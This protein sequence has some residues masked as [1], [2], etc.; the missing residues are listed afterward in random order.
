VPE[1]AP[2]T[3]IDGRYRVLDRLGS[4][5]MADVFCAEDTQLGRRVAL[6]LLH[7]RFAAD[8]EFVERFRREAQSAAGLQHPNI[9]GIYDRGQW[10][11]TSYIA[12]EYLP[13]RTLKELIVAEAPLAPQRAIE[14]TTQI[15]KGARFA[16]KRGVIHRDLKPHN[17]MVDDEDRVKVTDFGIARAG[18]SDM[19]ETGSILGT[20]QYLSPEQA[21]GHAVSEQSD[22]Y[23][24][25]VILYELLTGRLPFEAD[26][27]VAIAV[28]HVSETPPPP[29]ALNAAIPPELDRVVLWALEKDP[30]RRPPDADALLAAL[31][32]VRAGLGAG[33]THTTAFVP[34][35]PPPVA[36]PADE[37]PPDEVVVEEEPSRRR[38][39]LLL[40]LLL[41]LLAGGGL[42]AYLLTRPEKV[43]VLTV[44]GNTQAVAT[45][46]L[47]SEGLTVTVTMQPSSSKANEVISQNPLAGEQ[48]KKGS[49]VS[50]VVSSG[51]GQ[52]P[53]PNVRGA[54]LAS[55]RA[56]LKKAGFKVTT[57]E[58]ASGSVAE[59][60]VVSV[61]PDVGQRVDR[62]FTVSLTISSGPALVTIPGVIG[63]DRASARSELESRGF[64]VTE[65]QLES[66]KAVGTVLAQS[67]TAGTAVG[68]GTTVTI[69][70]A[71]EAPVAVPDVV[72]LG[73]DA[74]TN[75][76]TA[77]GFTT[78]VQ[79]KTVKTA[80]EDGKVTSQTPASGG[81]AKTGA[82]IT[83]VVGKFTP[84]NGQ[85]GTGTG[86]GTGTGPTTTPTQP[87]TTP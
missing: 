31:E 76:L 11:G 44:V 12:M 7:H 20:A 86:T 30:V 59:G 53:V 65:T 87:T 24:I 15:L 47:L 78:R 51:P 17:A 56:Q 71:I 62:G 52:A 72:G 19:T 84:T 66:T 75:K 82:A 55:A 25:G 38:R 63:Q 26:T 23:A 48:V 43:T 29:S 54:T 3:W 1:L 2:E 61:S 70:V 68:R 58:V 83:I 33:A 77:A 27:A 45:S 14:L 22:L 13:G 37:P 81:K 39:W 36:P 21:Q 32:E 80:A 73:S 35:T 79:T 41:I 67:P 74:A 57:Q 64:T 28:K 42:A 40:A 34:V 9:V 46:R 6:K 69:T 4:G 5:G 8:D 49:P 16:H 85:P 10:E 60:R 18:A 50:L